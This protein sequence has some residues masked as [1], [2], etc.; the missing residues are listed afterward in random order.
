M[1]TCALNFNKRKKR[2]QMINI[3]LYAPEIAQNTG[4]IGRSCVVAGA[5]LHLIKPYGF[6]IDE[7][8]LKRAGMDYWKKLNLFE[9]TTLEEF[10][11]KHGDKKIYFCS[12]FGKTLYT[13][14]EYEEDAFIMFGRESNGLPQMIHENYSEYLIRVPMKPVEEARSL[15]LS[16]TVSIVLYEALRQNNF[17]GLI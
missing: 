1:H 6:K 15:N 8:A 11:E 2:L 17:Q 16:N 12:K 10:L 3:V 9:Y 5:N 14:V 4:A 7:K 13:Q